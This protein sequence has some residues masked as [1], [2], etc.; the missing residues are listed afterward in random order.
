MTAQR[1][2]TGIKRLSAGAIHLLD[3]LRGYCAASLR[4]KGQAVADVSQERL[5]E[6]LHRSLPQVRRYVL[7]LV[8]HKLITVS[9]G[10]RAR[11][12]Y[13]VSDSNRSQVSGSNI[14]SMSDSNRSPMSGSNISSLSGSGPA[15]LSIDLVFTQQQQA[16]AAAES[17]SFSQRE[18]PAQPQSDP[19]VP[20]ATQARDA[21]VTAGVPEDEAREHS[22]EPA[23]CLFLLRFYQGEAEARAKTR[24]GRDDPLT[25]AFLRDH[26]RHPAKHGVTCAAGVWAAPKGSAMYKNMRDAEKAWNADRAKAQA[27]QRQAELR[28]RDE[29]LRR[30]PDASAAAWSALAE[31]DRRGIEAGVKREKPGLTPGGEMFLR[32]CYLRM[33]QFA[34]ALADAD[35]WNALT[36]DQRQAIE[37]DARA[38]FKLWAETEDGLRNACLTLMVSRAPAARTSLANPKGP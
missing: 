16:A 9:R 18:A 19:A 32:Q 8:K 2:D 17:F 15:P 37:R 26:L 31:A 3:L 22:A 24:R 20:T 13:E 5:A 28:A 27:A 10:Y 29:E 38:I 14:S 36:D 7:E 21:L 23:K 30:L 1:Q 33:K 34:Q 11:N 6:R 35:Q 25:I 12:Y 4:T